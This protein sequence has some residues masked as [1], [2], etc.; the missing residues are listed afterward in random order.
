M[1]PILSFIIGASTQI[2][3]IDPNATADRFTMNLFATDYN[4]YSHSYLCYGA[5]RLRFRYLGE[6][7]KQA[8]GSLSIND[9]CLQ[10]GYIENRTYDEIFNTACARDQYAP[11]P[12]LDPSSKFSFMYDYL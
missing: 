12:G 6:I 7:L 5:E 8:N 4:I 2:S 1:I 9:S 11:P 10:S 3:F